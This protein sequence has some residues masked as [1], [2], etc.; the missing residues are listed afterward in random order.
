MVEAA[1][2]S[3]AFDCLVLT[4]PW[5]NFIAGPPPIPEDM[6][7]AARSYP[8]DD[9]SLSKITNWYPIAVG[10]A[11]L[12]IARLACQRTNLWYDSELRSRYADWVLVVP[13][14]L[15]IVFLSV[16]LIQR[17]VLGDLVLAVGAPSAPLLV[18]A[19]REHFKQRDAAESQRRL[20]A[21]VES[22]WRDIFEKRVGLDDL[23]DRSREFQDAILE[24]R[25]SA[26]LLFPLVYHLMRPYMEQDMNRGAEARISE[27][28]Y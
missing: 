24:R 13:V 3:E 4:L 7:R 27:L 1:A 17:L 8:E 25:R 2:Y 6:S 12:E 23:T 19:I 16:G 21:V 26:P 20:M 11:P 28:G 18:W 22:L 14:I 9:A 15:T 5:N 10:K